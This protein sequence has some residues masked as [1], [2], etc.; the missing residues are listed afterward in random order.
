MSCP[1]YNVTFNLIKNK[2]Y[3]WVFLVKNWLFSSIYS[4]LW[5]WKGYHVWIR[6]GFLWLKGDMKNKF[7]P[8]KF[9]K[10]NL[11]NVE[12]TFIKLCFWWV[13]PSQQIKNIFYV[14]DTKYIVFHNL[15]K[16]GG[17]GSILKFAAPNFEAGIG[18]R[19]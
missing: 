6:H 9:E 19:I 16:R 10:K 15:I 3:V 1:I 12:S 11:E 13:E 4:I 2:Q 18:P 14:L 7:G 5:L 17:G 8:I